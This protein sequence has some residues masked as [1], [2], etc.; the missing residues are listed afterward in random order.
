MKEE[1]LRDW[2]RLLSMYFWVCWKEAYKEFLVTITKRKHLYPCRT[3]KL[4]SYVPKILA[5]CPAGKIGCC[6]VFFIY[7]YKKSYNARRIST[8]NYYIVEMFLHYSFFISLYDCF[9]VII[10]LCSFLLIYQL[11]HHVIWKRHFLYKPF[12]FC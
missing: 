9:A 6:Q 12:A 11:F 2:R 1:G 5:G 8:I 7:F 4:S 3:Q 10:I